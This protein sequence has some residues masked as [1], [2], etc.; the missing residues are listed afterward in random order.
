MGGDIGATLNERVDAFIDRRP[1]DNYPPFLS[2]KV[3]LDNPDGKITGEIRGNGWTA[4]V[5]GYRT[6]QHSTTSPSP[7]LGKSLNTRRES[8]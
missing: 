4:E 7:F 6:D 3:N 8:K 2:F 1:Y 5:Q